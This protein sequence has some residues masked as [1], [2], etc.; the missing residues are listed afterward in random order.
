MKPLLAIDPGAIGG[1]AY[2]DSDGLFHAMAMPETEGDI[3]D[4]LTEIIAMGKPQAAYIE[5]L[6]GYVGTAIPSHTMLKLGRNIGFLIGVLQSRGI[7]IIE[8]TPQAWQKSL[9]IGTA[10]GLKKHEWKAKL[11]AECQRRFPVLT[12]GNVTL[13][14]CDAL[15]ILHY[16][17][18]DRQ[19]TY[20]S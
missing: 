2:C 16:G 9:N 8:V 10:G 12:D 14:T 19:A 4:A 15:L 18:R 13:S 20:Q 7:P 17:L 6:T 3:C 5:K 1:I 11:K